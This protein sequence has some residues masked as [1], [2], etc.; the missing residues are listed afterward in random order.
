LDQ[1]IVIVDETRDFPST[2][3]EAVDEFYRFVL[4]G[5]RYEEHEFGFPEDAPI[6]AD[7]GPYSTVVWHADDY[8]DFMASASSDAI[9]DYLDAG[10]KLWFMGWKPTSGLSGELIYPMEFGPGDFIYDYLAISR[11]ELSTI[12][13]PVVGVD[14]LLDFPSMT[15]DSA[16]IP[17]PSWGGALRYVE[18]L[19]I[20]STAE[21]VYTIDMEDD[22]SSFEGSTCGLRYL[23]SDHQIVFFGFPLYFMD[24]D[25]ARAVAQ[26][27]MS[28]F[29]ELSGENWQDNGAP[30]SFLKLYQNTPNPFSTHTTIGY[31]VPKNGPVRLQIFDLG[32]RLVRTLI[33]DTQNTGSHTA[34]WDGLGKDYTPVGNGVYLYRVEAG[35]SSLM[36]RMV[37]IR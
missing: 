21:G 37:L 34:R 3:D 18:A 33:D 6:L 17:V 10:G 11:A 7:L 22:G 4:D 13:D 32:G 35:N 1:G 23:G 8:S 20:L 26:K 30:V 31:A 36:R 29:G 2:P 15:V 19:T 25:Q 27:V 5:F 28:D 14:G 24:Q 9:Q 16:K 12:V